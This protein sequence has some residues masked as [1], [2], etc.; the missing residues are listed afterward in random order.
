[1]IK[2]I[3]NTKYVEFNDEGDLEQLLIGSLLGDGCFTKISGN[4]KNSRFSMA[5]SLKQKEYFMFKQSILDKYNLSGKIS[6]N[7]IVSNRYK[8]GFTEE[9]RLK[10]KSHPI[11][12]FYRQLYDISGKKRINKE[13][14]NKLNPL[15]LSIWYMDDGNITGYSCEF[16]VQSFTEEERIV[17]QEVLKINFNI[18]TTLTNNTIYILSE[19]FENFINII[20]RF[21]IPS[22]EYKLK[23]YKKGSV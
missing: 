7:K 16:N 22:M 9:I 5:H 1:M 15:G 17:L 23:P 6:E 18:K 14:I 2:R 12:T 13:I 3:K 4:V 19:D 21:I 8:E 20:K 10:S 11:F